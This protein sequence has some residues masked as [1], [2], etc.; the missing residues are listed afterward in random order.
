M[1]TSVKYKYI[2]NITG[3]FTIINNNYVK[4]FKYILFTY[5]L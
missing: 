5:I 1:F 4:K 2:C 3:M